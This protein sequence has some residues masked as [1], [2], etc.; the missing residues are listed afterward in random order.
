MAPVI[1]FLNHTG[2]ERLNLE[3]GHSD[4]SNLSKMPFIERPILSIMW[5]QGTRSRALLKAEGGGKFVW[6]GHEPT[7]IVAAAASALDSHRTQEDVRGYEGD[8][9]NTTRSTSG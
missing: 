7:G 2:L 3:N 5:R 9:Q 1:S 4:G 8:R 6:D